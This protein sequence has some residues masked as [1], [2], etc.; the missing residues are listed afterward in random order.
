MIIYALILATVL[1]F[2]A[3][4]LVFKS[5]NQTTHLIVNILTTLFLG[6]MI[7]LSALN[8]N[9][10]LGM[11]LTNHTHTEKIA[12]VASQPK[13]LINEKLGKQKKHDLVVY[14][15]NGK[16]THTGLD[17]SVTNH[18][19]RTHGKQAV[20]KVTKK[21]W[22]AKPGISHLWFSLIGKKETAQ[23]VN[24]FYVP[25]NWQVMSK[26]QV[27]VFKATAKQAAAKAQQQAKNPAVKMQM[28]QQAKAAVQKAEM[29]AMQKHPKMT[30]A[31]Q[32]AVAKR[33]LKKFKQQMK[34]KAMQP[35]MIKALAKAKATPAGYMTK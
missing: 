11:N 32:K 2:I 15:K 27:N 35:I 31:Q 28:K 26:Q 19:K 30:K 6:G 3:W 4:N 5:E 33:A 25:K 29:T 14:K 1:F 18:I 9:Q 22:N 21:T 24:T 10:H 23:T 16:T 7:V 20:V 17:T 8:F 13:L 34:A 12:S